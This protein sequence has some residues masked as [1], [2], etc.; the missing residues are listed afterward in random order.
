[1]AG[2][3]AQMRLIDDGSGGGVS[4]RAVPLPVVRGGIKHDAFHRGWRVVA[5]PARRLATVILRN[6]NP[7]AVRVEE[8]LR[9]IKTHPVRGIIRSL[10]A[11]A[12]DLPRLH[13]RHE[14]V[15]VVVS[16]VDRGID[17]HD[18]RGPAVIVAIEEDQLHAR[19]TPRVHA[20]INATGTD[21]SAQ[22]RASA[23][24]ADWI[25]IDA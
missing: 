12:V 7:P 19:G 9:G 4:D 22:W 17:G 3:S 13:A 5:F 25:H 23:G 2:E 14:N 1:M 18:A 6:E 8:N 15:P 24:I 20:E 10:N 11:I 21:G 16:A